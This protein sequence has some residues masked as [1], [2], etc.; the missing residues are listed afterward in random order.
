M[1]EYL[2]ISQLADRYVVQ[3][4][5][6]SGTATTIGEFGNHDRALDHVHLTAAEMGAEPVETEHNV[7]ALYTPRPFYFQ[8]DPALVHE[9]TPEH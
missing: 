3:R 1:S 8:H 4:E 7:F 9:W 6:G 2:T 5:T